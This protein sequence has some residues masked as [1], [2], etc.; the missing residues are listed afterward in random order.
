MSL[1]QVHPSGTPEDVDGAVLV[2]I[3]RIRV[4]PPLGS[5]H[6]E[7]VFEGI[8]DGLFSLSSNVGTSIFA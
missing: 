4:L 6:A 1:V 5:D 3:F 8:G 2:D 7:L